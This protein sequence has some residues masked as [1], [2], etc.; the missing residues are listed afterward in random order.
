MTKPIKIDE[1]VKKTL[2][3]MK[4]SKIMEDKKPIKFSENIKISKPNSDWL[5]AYC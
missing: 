3:G 4:K 1:K 2:D 5:C